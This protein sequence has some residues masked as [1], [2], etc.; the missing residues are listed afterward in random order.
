MVLDELH[1][2]G[3][4]PLSIGWQA[5]DLGITRQL[6]DVGLKDRSPGAL[7]VDVHVARDLP[8]GNADLDPAL[9]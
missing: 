3:E 7:P 6:G 9:R 2:I 5:E 1:G 8:L 4:D